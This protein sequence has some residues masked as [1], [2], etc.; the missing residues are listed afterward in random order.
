MDSAG[1][2]EEGFLQ[3]LQELVDRGQT[4]AEELLALYH[5]EWRGDLSR[6]FEGYNFL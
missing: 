5:G 3:P 2:T 4:R 6:M 1:S